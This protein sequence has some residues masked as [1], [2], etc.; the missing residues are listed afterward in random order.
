MN[1]SAR[2]PPTGSARAARIAV[3]LLA[4]VAAL[5]GCG[6]DASP[7]AADPAV[8][9]AAGPPMAE[10][11][12]EVAARV[13][14]ENEYLGEG[15]L[16][17]LR[18]RL[19]GTRVQGGGEERYRL[20]CAVADAEMIHGDLDA[21]LRLLEEARGM[22]DRS[23]PRVKAW[24][25]PDVLLK[26]GV[27]HLRRAEVENCCARHSADSCVIPIR[28]KGVHG[29]TE[30]STAAIAS[31]TAAWN[32]AKAGSPQRDAA[33][34]LLN[35]AY[36]TLGRWPREVPKEQLVPSTA[37]GGDYDFPRFDNVAATVGFDFF[38]LSGGALAEDYDGDGRIDLMISSWDPRKPARLFRN[39]GDGAFAEVTKEANLET[40]LGGLNAVAADY[41]GDG[42]VDVF[43]PRGGWLG[44][45]GRQPKSLLRNDGRGRFEDVALE[46]GLGG[47][48]YPSQAAAFADY[49]L[50]GDLDLFTASEAEPRAGMNYPCLL[51]RN[52]GDGT[53]EELGAEAGVTNLRRAKGC[54]WGDYDGDGD[55][56][57]YVSNVD[58]D[59]R[60]YRNDGGRFVD[61]APELGVTKP[62]DGFPCWFFD[63][64][65]DGALDL[66]AAA[67]FRDVAP[68]G[69]AYL[70]RP[71]PAH[72]CRLYRGDGKGGFADVTEEV[73]LTRV[74]PVMGANFG[75]LDADGY[76][77]IYLATG[78]PEYGALAPNILYRNAAADDGRRIYR[79]VT[80]ASRF[81]IL[82]KGHG[83]AF[84]DFDGDGDLDVF[85][86]TGGAY[87][88]DTFKNALFE[89]PGFGNHRL[90]VKLQGTRS[91]RAGYGAR[92][93]AEIE[94]NGAT[95]SVYA[96][97]GCTSSFG[98]NPSLAFLGLGKATTVKTLEVRWP[99]SPDP[100]VFHDVPADRTVVIVE[101]AATLQPAAEPRSAFR[102][103]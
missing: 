91:N 51:Y 54:A 26:I 49:D 4:C 84:A 43:V 5:A 79:D 101:G 80:V 81:G 88:T 11:L 58:D 98:G 16:K 73:G 75:D 13:E 71:D 45:A 96:H 66:F 85:A 35:V 2:R 3:S 39:G 10:R 33:Q 47:R 83:V 44:K 64:D 103:S 77:E 76:P 100:Q 90:K 40:A 82:Q 69:A 55:P 89:N 23:E 14:T 36:M 15:R 94:E 21:A 27:V 59:N 67:F 61:V 93:R 50:D 18:A 60:L 68:V 97:V 52:E 20:L 30:P 62:H 74:A 38:N 17:E 53:F 56:D 46:A 65:G 78:A 24:L 6:G 8:V 1:D 86:Q 22:V 34:W 70:G 57:L 37:L 41:D 7:A 72:Y 48:D 92:I 102:R 29:K 99:R 42:D 32:A 25:Y 95:R 63:Y 9:A 12:R 31:F 28:G 19:E 87:V